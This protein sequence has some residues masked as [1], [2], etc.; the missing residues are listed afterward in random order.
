M[1]LGEAEQIFAY[2]SENPPA[3]LM[4]QAIAR[5]L[6]W[7]P[8]RPPQPGLAEIAVMA[9]PGLSIA[10]AGDIGMPPPVLDVDALRVRNRARLAKTRDPM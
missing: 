3:H 10:K 2:W 8:P 5:M 1:T 9:P 4:L 6:G 7:K